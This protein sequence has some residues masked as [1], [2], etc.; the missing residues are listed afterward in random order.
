MW[1]ATRPKLVGEDFE[2]DLIYLVEDRHHSL[3]NDFVLECRDA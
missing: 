3:L 2:V 1:A